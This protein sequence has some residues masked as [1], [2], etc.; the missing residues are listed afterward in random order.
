MRIF[1]PV[2]ILIF[3]LQSLAQSD[4]VR[5]FEIEGTSIGNSLLDYYDEKKIKDGI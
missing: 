4:D 3:S 1:F 5:D 2:L